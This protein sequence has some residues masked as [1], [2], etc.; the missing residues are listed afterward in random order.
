[1]FMHDHVELWTCLKTLSY[2]K[3]NK[4]FWILCNT[5]SLQ[6]FFFFNLELDFCRFCVVIRFFHLCHNGQWP[7]FLILEERASIFPFECSVPNKGT[8]GT[9]FITSLVW[10][11]PWL[12]IEP[13]TSS[14]R[15]QHST[16]RLPR[17]RCLQWMIP[18]LIF[19]LGLTLLQ[20]AGF[21][22]DLTRV[23]IWFKLLGMLLNE[24]FLRVLA[25]EALVILYKC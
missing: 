22:W 9:I 8:T 17:T 3:K 21:I 25:F 13:R 20:T 6:W 2:L 18:D 11:D 16:T 15:S 23:V 12:G 14:T 19:G 4:R 24:L 10:R 5:Y 1:M 7:Y